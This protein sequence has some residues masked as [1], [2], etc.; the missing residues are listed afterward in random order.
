VCSSLDEALERGDFDGVVI[1][2]PTFTHHPLAV[3]ALEAGLHVHLEKPMAMN[4]RE[5]A[6]ITAAAERAGTA[7]QLGFMRRFDRDFVQAAECCAAAP[8]AP[9][10][11][12]SR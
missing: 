2:T 7:L 4:L 11:S 3:R 1:T 5:C 8:S 10:S 12:S 6:A 9:R